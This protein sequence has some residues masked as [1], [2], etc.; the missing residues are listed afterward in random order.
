MKQAKV[1]APGDLAV[2]GKKLEI[3]DSRDELSVMRQKAREE[4]GSRSR[5]AALARTRLEEFERKTR[6]GLSE[7]RSLSPDGQRKKEYLARMA[8]DTS[9]EADVANAELERI[10]RELA[11]AEEALAA[12]K[13]SAANALDELVAE[14]KEKT[15]RLEKIRAGIA[16]L[17]LDLEALHDSAPDAA[18][19]ELK[20]SDF[21]CR[22]AVGEKIAESEMKAL[23]EER[24]LIEAALELAQRKAEDL[25]TALDGLSTDENNLTDQ[26]LALADKE[27]GLLR[28]FILEKVLSLSGEYAAAA[29]AMAAQWK[30]MKGMEDLLRRNGMAA[31]RVL[32]GNMEIPRIVQAGEGGY[33]HDSALFSGALETQ[34]GTH[35]QEVAPLVKKLRDKGLNI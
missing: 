12:A 9:A 30:L 11:Q 18:D 23:D 33:G 14:R 5:S 16:R 26:L 20:R 10:E 22:R 1:T 35:L 32:S 3:L 15:L 17:E 8:Q 6:N 28:E 7:P 21:L 4:A 27:P 2:Y 29:K 34:R 25:L 31:A 19:V 24:D 13:F